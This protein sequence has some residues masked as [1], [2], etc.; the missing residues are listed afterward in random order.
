MPQWAQKKERYQCRE[1]KTHCQHEKRSSGDFQPEFYEKSA[2]Y[3]LRTRKSVYP[4]HS[5]SIDSALYPVSFS[6]SA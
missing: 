3:D 5:Q 6:S 4:T 1:N 2:A